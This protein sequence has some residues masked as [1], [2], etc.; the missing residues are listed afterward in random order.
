MKQ[1]FFEGDYICKIGTTKVEMITEVEPFFELDE[2]VYYTD[3]GNSYGITQIEP[4]AVTY[5][6]EYEKRL[7]NKKEMTAEAQIEEILHEAHAY[8]IREE[9]M[10]YA[11]Q[12]MDEGYDKITAYELAYKEWVK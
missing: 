2:Y 3:K 6:R 11:R 10:M 12:F 4:M 5:Q 9:V 1:Q 7:T 8:G